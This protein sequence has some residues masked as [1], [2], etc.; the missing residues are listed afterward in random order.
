MADI[1]IS[2]RERT[3][4]KGVLAPFGEYLREVRVFGSRALG[5]ARPNSDIDL[6]LY[7]DQ[8]ERM[9]ARLW[10]LFDDS[11]LAVTVDLIDYARLSHAPLRRHIDLVGR[12]LFTRDDLQKAERPLAAATD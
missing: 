10:T 6:A 9:V 4:V 7:G 8:D 2:D 12:L 3:I 5:N 11:S 1:M